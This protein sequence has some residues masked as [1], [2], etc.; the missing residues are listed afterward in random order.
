[1]GEIV[2]FIDADI[3]V[4]SDTLALVARAF[5]SEAYA[6]AVVGMLDRETPCKAL[7]SQYFNIRKHYDYLLIKG[8]LKNLYTSVMAIRREAFL[9]VGGFDAS[10]ARAS[11]EDAEL[12]RR[13][14]SLDEYERIAGNLKGMHSLIVSGGEPFLRQDLPEIIGAFYEK[15]SVR[16]VSIP[17]NL[18]VE[19]AAEK[20]AEI[21]L[22]HPKA[23]FRILISIDGVGAKHDAIR[24]VEG[25]FDRLIANYE[26]LASYRPA[27]DNLSLNAAIVLSAFN[28]ASIGEVL[29][30]AG[31]L[32]VDDVKLILA[33]GSTRDPSARVVSQGAYREAAHRG[34]EERELVLQ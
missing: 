3:V 34:K 33:R 13:L 32:E 15:A 30:F 21:V 5:E 4:K 14:L 11:T 8:D 17:T 7:A 27:L 28:E 20:I 10:Y 22:R 18:F 19:D 6:S 29:D 2:L 31:L 25:G 1:M 9:S 23:Y 12:G 24:G 26:R 16:Q